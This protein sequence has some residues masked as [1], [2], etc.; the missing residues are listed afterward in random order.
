[1]CSQTGFQ[2]WLLAI[3]K[4]LDF[5]PSGTNYQPLLMH[6]AHI[7]GLLTHGVCLIGLCILQLVQEK[8]DMH[9]QVRAG[10][11]EH[12][13]GHKMLQ[14]AQIHGLTKIFRYL[15]IQVL[16]KQQIALEAGGWAT[17]SDVRLLLALSFQCS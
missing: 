3:N 4:F 1:M 7:L 12:R 16:R 17:E 9:C 11:V 13:I 10:C 2:I 6:L 8:L 15:S 5:P 14:V